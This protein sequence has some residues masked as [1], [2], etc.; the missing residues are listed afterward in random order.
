MLS[1]FAFSFVPLEWQ[2]SFR[3]FERLCKESDFKEIVYNTVL[4][5]NFI[6]PINIPEKK[7]ILDELI[8]AWLKK[9]YFGM[10]GIVMN[11]F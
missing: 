7:R 3:E 6:I 4:E 2:P 5:K 1:W 9:K 11:Y 10:I 8:I